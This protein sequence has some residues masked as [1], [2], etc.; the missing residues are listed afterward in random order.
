MRNLK[1]LIKEQASQIP[2]EDRLEL[3]KVL[4]GEQDF[5]YKLEPH[6]W[7]RINSAGDDSETEQRI[8][9]AKSKSMCI[10]GALAV[11]KLSPTATGHDVV[12]VSA[13][14]M[15]AFGIN[16]SALDAIIDN[17]GIPQFIEELRRLDAE[18]RSLDFSH[19]ASNI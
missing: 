17:D 11:S 19:G 3:V 7:I 5:G 2:P 12:L 1:E 6:Y 14:Y 9:D 15:Q 13:L 10:I 18:E 8:C 4:E 16:T